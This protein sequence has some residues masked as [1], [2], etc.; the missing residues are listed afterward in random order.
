MT[1]TRRA[2]KGYVY[3]QQVL[4]FF[5]ALMDTKRDI[6]EIEAE[7][8]VKHNFDDL[9]VVRDKEYFIQIKNYPKMTM[10]DIKIKDKNIIMLGNKNEYDANKNNVIV[11]NSENIVT[12]TDFWGLEAALINGIYVIPLTPDN[13]IDEM[14]NM[15]F[16][17]TRVKVILE[18]SYRLTVNEKFSLRID[19][20]PK[21][22]TISMD[23]EDN[24]IL[25]R[26][27]ETLTE[28]GCQFIIGKPGVG[29]SHYAN[30]INKKYS[31]A[32][33]YRFWI[34]SQ[35][36]FIDKRLE[37]GEFLRTLSFLIF[38]TPK[39]HSEAEI[40]SKMNEDELTIIIDGLDHVENYKPREL[41]RY[42]AFFGKITNASVVILSRPLRHEIIYP[43]CHL[44]NWTQSETV[45]YLNAA[46]TIIDYSVTQRIYEITQGYPILIT[47]LANHYNLFG[48][49]NLES[50]VSAIDDYYEI[51]LNNIT[52]KTAMSLFMINSSFILKEEIPWLLNNEMLS[53][54]VLEFIQSYPYL[55]KE[56]GDRV[57]LI[58]DS[59]NTYLRNLDLSDDG[60]LG[61]GRDFVI[62]S[63]M[64]EEI[65][66]LSRFG[67]FFIADDDK[68]CI[69]KKY[70]TLEIFNRLI[71]NNYDF[72]S[73][74]EFYFAI[75]DEL[76]NFRDVLDI[77]E[78]Y[79][80]ILILLCIERNNLVG[81]DL[82]L[83]QL[84]RYLYS[85]HSGELKIYSSGALWAAYQ[86]E[87]NNNLYPMRK[88]LSEHSYSPD[89][90]AD[91]F[92]VLEDEEH[93]FEKFNG[94][95]HS[96]ELV[97]FLK[98]SSN[99]GHQK[100]KALILLMAEVYIKQEQENGYYK[101]IQEY[102]ENNKQQS[103]NEI[104][105]KCQDLGIE[106]FWGYSILEQ[107]KYQIW[108]QG[109]GTQNNPLRN[110]SLSKI[111]S[112]RASIGSFDVG[113]YV[114]SYLRLSIHVQEEIDINSI[115]KFVMMYYNR[116]DYSVYSFP[117]LLSIFEQKGFIKES[118]SIDL[119][120]KLMNQSEK[121]IRHILTTYLSNKESEIMLTHKD[122]FSTENYNVNYFDLPQG[123]IDQLEREFIF[124][125]FFKSLGRSN[126]IS[127]YEIKQLLES[128]H[129]D[130]LI[131][132]INN[133]NIEIFDVPKQ[134]LAF[135]D[136]L[137]IRTRVNK[138]E[139]T[140][141]KYIPFEHGNI[142]LKDMEYIESAGMTYLELAS[143]TDGWHNSLP[144]TELFA[145]FSKEELTSNILI[146]LHN[147]LN[148]KVPRLD[149]LAS[150]TL[151]PG[152]VIKLFYEI[153]L[154]VNWDRIYASFC[155]YL[156]VSLIQ[157][158]E[159]KN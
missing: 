24:T 51:L 66:F 101:I 16:D 138:D 15:Y 159:M 11:V 120:I 45:N 143:Y 1:I 7:N 95:S 147:V 81:D 112:N 33:M 89:N 114:V 105:G 129:S 64:N 107:A 97:A 30:E 25:V 40:L 41:E 3:Q 6:Y 158:H 36:Q 9:R 119:L 18:Y 8:I 125:Y 72:D 96:E 60:L 55:F 68:K 54:I 117:A 76:E 98:G 109:Y 92:K 104:K 94:N 48:E 153:E 35:D 140:G 42:F 2:F 86:L 102:V 26:E 84:V 78:Y 121:G 136:G 49:I 156:D 152:N 74:K 155:T 133:Y 108:E 4:S 132:I 154:D 151:L 63:I 115:N 71:T 59:F 145:H 70:S 58:H 90:I 146:I 93:F 61:Y 34:G 17:D 85:F 142:H 46:F 111:I 131:Q 57:S 79:D 100:K 65:R 10:D 19:D 12:T 31:E 116:K 141:D 99:Y 43:I 135:F 75:R 62:N 126:L 137:G 27:V 21:F 38:N 127:F 39:L 157:Y 128:K 14:E 122:K 53:K 103:I 32:I 82:L 56:T 44:E 88:L 106:S 80:L 77:Y 22:K 118:E 28:K 123:H 50:R 83:H 144:Y 113:Q 110:T 139:K 29:K 150:Y 23:L 52:T 91:Y 134:R 73:I 149:I 20:L 47:F 5:I 37:F 13:I 69:I 67:T 148:A 124:A 87:I 130:K